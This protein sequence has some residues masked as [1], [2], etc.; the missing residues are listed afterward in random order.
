MFCSI[1]YI[2]YPLWNIWKKVIV[3]L[4]PKY[5]QMYLFIRA[6]CLAKLCPYIHTNNFPGFTG[7]EKKGNINMSS[8]SFPGID[9]AIEGQPF[10][11]GT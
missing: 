10:Q 4:P 7:K 6:K 1:Y 8:R 3:M 11:T 5:L 9:F 2:V